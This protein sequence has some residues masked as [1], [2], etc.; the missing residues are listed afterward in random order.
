MLNEVTY[1][2]YGEVDLH[3]H[4]GL[5]DESLRTESEATNEWLELIAQADV[6][7]QMRK[8]LIGSNV[9]DDL[10]D[11]LLAFVFRHEGE[12]EVRCGTG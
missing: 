3:L 5:I 2:G 11:Q 10:D 7:L 8:I 6:R 9:R 1:A 4:H 12:D